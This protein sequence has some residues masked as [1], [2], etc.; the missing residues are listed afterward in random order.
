MDNVRGGTLRPCSKRAVSVDAI[1]NIPHEPEGWGWGTLSTP[2]LESVDMGLPFAQKSI[3][4][5]ADR[6]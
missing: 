2:K 1:V 4:L 6:K 3:L 5:I